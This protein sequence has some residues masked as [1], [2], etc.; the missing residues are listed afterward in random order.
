[1][2]DGP[3]AGRDGG[4]DKPRPIQPPVERHDTAMALTWTRVDVLIEVSG[5]SQAFPEGIVRTGGRYLIVGQVHAQSMPFNPSSIVIEHAHLIGAL[6]G[7]V[8]DHAGGLAFI[9]HH[10][11]RFRWARQDLE[12]LPPRSDQPGLPREAG[13]YGDQ[14]ERREA[15]IGSM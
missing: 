14:A 5:L 8:A 15:E 7:S 4:R 1:M 13:S 12:P 10:R 6:S 2:P 9:D 11:E 3:A